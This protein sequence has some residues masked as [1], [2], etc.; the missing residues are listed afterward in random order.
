MTGQD[1]RSREGR[2][3]EGCLIQVLTCLAIC[4]LLLFNGIFVFSVYRQLE[5]VGPDILSQPKLAQTTLFLGPILMI[6]IEYWLFDLFF[7]RRRSG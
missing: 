1:E 2:S 5:E 6:L 7:T 4:A 3:R